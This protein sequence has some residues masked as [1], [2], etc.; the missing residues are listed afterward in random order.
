MAAETTEG[1]GW[2]GYGRYERHFVYE[3]YLR[4]CPE[5][6]YVMK[7][8]FGT[9]RMVLRAYNDSSQLLILQ[10]MTTLWDIKRNMDKLRINDNSITRFSLEMIF[11]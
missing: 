1:G 5:I 2:T 3:D 8:A 6:F 10:P 4:I 7:G 9:R 11:T